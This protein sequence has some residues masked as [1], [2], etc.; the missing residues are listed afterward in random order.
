MEKWNF[1]K[2]QI[3]NQTEAI[4]QT[5]YCQWALLHENEVEGEVY[6]CVTYQ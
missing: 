1:R 3:S 6:M 4:K 5:K 2:K